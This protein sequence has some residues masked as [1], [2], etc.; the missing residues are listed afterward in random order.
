[1][2]ND[3]DFS[4][5]DR[6]RK[7]NVARYLGDDIDESFLDIKKTLHAQERVQQRAISS[8]MELLIQIFGKPEM[9]KGGTDVLRIPNKVIKELRKAIDKIDNVNLVFNPETN[10]LITAFHQDKKIRTVRNQ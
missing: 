5:Y 6:K 9:Q 7:Y 4:Q 10:T 3:K 1:M 8:E 2:T